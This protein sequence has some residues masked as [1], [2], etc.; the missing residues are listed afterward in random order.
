MTSST[1]QKAKVMAFFE[2]TL[3]WDL[4]FI[5]CIIGRLLFDADCDRWVM[6]LLRKLLGDPLRFQE[7]DEKL[8]CR[9]LTVTAAKCTSSA[10]RVSRINFRLGSDI[11][12]HTSTNKGLKNKNYEA[13][14]QHVPFTK[15]PCASY[16]N[17]RSVVLAVALQFTPQIWVRSEYYFKSPD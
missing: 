7:R 4:F 9:R 5:K 2:R 15:L 3:L 10:I 13:V 11:F 1:A 12:L 14:K 6:Y 16:V 17:L 8:E